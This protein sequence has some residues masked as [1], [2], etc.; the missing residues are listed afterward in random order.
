M[1]RGPLIG[2]GGAIV[3]SIVLSGC[4]TLP[5]LSEATGGIPVYDI[6]LRTKC[7]LSDALQDDY[8]NWLVDFDK[9]K[10][11]EN[12]VAQVDFTLQILDQATLS[13]GASVIQPLH[14]AYPRGVGPSTI[15]TSGVLGTT[16]AAVPQSFAIAGGVNLNGQA[17]RTQTMSFAFSVK[18]LGNWRSRPNTRQLCALSDGMDLRGRLGLKEWFREAV[19][20]V[21]SN[22]ELL[23]AGYHPKQAPG[24]PQQSVT[25]PANAVSNATIRK[26]IQKL[27][28]CDDKYLDDQLEALNAAKDTVAAAVQVARDASILADNAANDK[29]SADATLKKARQTIKTDKTRFGAVLDPAIKQKED[30]S[31]KNIKRADQFSATIQSNLTAAQKEFDQLKRTQNTALTDAVSAIRKANSTIESARKKGQCDKVAL[32]NEVTQAVAAAAD[33]QTHANNAAENVALAKKNIEDMKTILDTVTEFTSKPI[34]PPIATIGQSIQFI[35]TYGGNVTPTWTFVRFKG[36]NSPLFLTSGTRTH[37]LNITLGPINPTTNAP[38]ADV[39]QN[40]FY[41]QLNNLL[42]PLTL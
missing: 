23:Y 3:C 9:Y 22:R 41:L 16:V 29:M 19:E 7:E 15:S 37:T 33:V 32:E 4:A 5:Q 25:K 6:V 11:L 26:G 10:W 13:P 2:A 42:S 36:P 8:G 28:A 17:Q 12:W 1:A 35:L 39:K 38:N 18:E 24:T 14:N 31:D 27:E 20:P 34:D 21:V 30:E 40:Q